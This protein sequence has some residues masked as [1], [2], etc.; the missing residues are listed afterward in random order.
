MN[1]I[2][3]F[4]ELAELTQSQLAGII[5]WGQGRLSNYE[6]GERSPSLD[7]MRR[8]VAALGANG[9]PCTLDEVFPSDL[10]ADL[11]SIQKNSLK[12]AAR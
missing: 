10:A 7:D 1:K 12:L 2:R 9:A 6:T 8:I 5:G 4:R 11:V 3:Q